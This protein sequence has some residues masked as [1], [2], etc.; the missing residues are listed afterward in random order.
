MGDVRDLA[1][2]PI[3]RPVAAAIAASERNQTLPAMAGICPHCG[4]IM[5]APPLRRDISDEPFGA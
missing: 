2:L 1:D 4:S 5:A 3:A